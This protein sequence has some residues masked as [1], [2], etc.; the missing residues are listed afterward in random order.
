MR[1]ALMRAREIITA[2]AAAVRSAAALTFVMGILLL[3]AAVMA[4]R[5]HRAHDAVI[6]QVLGASRRTAA[7]IFL[8]EHGAPGIATAFVA[9]ALG[10]AAAYAVV[11]QLMELPWHLAPAAVAV[12][13]LVGAGTSLAIGALATLYALRQSPAHLLRED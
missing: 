6:F 1:D 10:S 13:V 5:R 8:V 2:I 11:A 12:T 7:F 3:A 9:S 4:T